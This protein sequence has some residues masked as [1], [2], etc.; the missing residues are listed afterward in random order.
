MIQIV[1][2]DSTTRQHHEQVA[3]GGGHLFDLPPPSDLPQR[4]NMQGS[5]P[6]RKASTSWGR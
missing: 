3:G 5:F 1:G 4:S 2:V 6:Q